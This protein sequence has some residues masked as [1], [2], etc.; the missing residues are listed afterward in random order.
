MF[1]VFLGKMS[2][3]SA[4]FVRTVHC[5]RLDEFAVGRVPEFLVFLGIAFYRLALSNLL[6]NLLSKSLSNLLNNLLSNSQLFLGFFVLPSSVSTVEW[7][8]K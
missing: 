1:T 2:S 7:Y 5:R 4:G 6:S 8:S 3:L